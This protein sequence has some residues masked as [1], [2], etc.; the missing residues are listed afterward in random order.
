MKASNKNLALICGNLGELYNDGIEIVMAIEL[1]SDLPIS[2]AY[3]DSLI[4]IR[5]DVIKG[6]GIAEAFKNYSLLYPSFFTGMLGLGE[7]SGQL[8]KVLKS[9]QEYY[10]HIDK[11]KRKTISS[12]IYPA[13]LISALIVLLIILV[14]VVIPN[15]EQM[16]D[17]NGLAMPAIV[18]LLQSFRKL[19]VQKPILLITC[20]V[21]WGIGI[22]I[23]IL[24]S[25]KI[26]SF[27]MNFVNNLKIMKQINEYIFVLILS[28]ILK[29][30][31]PLIN[32]LEI[33]SETLEFTTIVDKLEMIKNDIL[34]GDTLS[35]SLE[36]SNILSKYSISMIGLGEISGGLVEKVSKLELRMEGILNEKIEKLIG[37][38][39]PI[40]ITIMGVSIA[41][42]ICI[43]VLPMFDVMYGGIN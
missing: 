21:S 5:N 36:K 40:M 42:F 33:V 31:I 9:M 7:K 43:F 26:K 38:I 18:K 23:L 14:F 32:G 34:M 20:L 2:K 10:E 39:E 13:F 28:I 15:F 27:I 24:K 22:P 41:V 6:K 30:G 4:N 16:F 17:D 35:S 25:S 11:V 37:I 29:S 1:L 8:G 3:K 12:L 19:C